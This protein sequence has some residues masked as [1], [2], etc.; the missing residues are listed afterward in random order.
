MTMTTS[1]SIRTI[2]PATALLALAAPLALTACNWDREFGNE[3]EYGSHY[4]RLDPDIGTNQF[5]WHQTDLSHLVRFMPGTTA[6]GGDEAVKLNQFIDQVGM[7]PND[8]VT[9]IVGGPMGAARADAVQQAFALRGYRITPVVDPYL[10]DGD[11]TVNIRRVVYTASACLTEGNQL[12]DGTPVIPMGCA[13]ALNLQRMVVNPD[14]LVD[15][16]LGSDTVET[17][18]AVD[19]IQRYRR[20]E[21]TPLMSSDSSSSSGE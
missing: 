18:P 13:N 12:A 21:I 17:V 20:G 19:T 7:Q 3:F 1:P 8:E 6:I 5:A 4:A 2:R 15:G 11:V 16:G 10:A 14:E 9:A